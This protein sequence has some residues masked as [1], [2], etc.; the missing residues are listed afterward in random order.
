MLIFYENYVHKFINHLNFF[1]ILMIL[2]KAITALVMIVLS[3]FNDFHNGFI[4][5]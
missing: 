4:S 1:L 3:H 5:I 2:P